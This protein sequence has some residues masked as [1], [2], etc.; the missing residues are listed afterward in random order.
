ML[1]KVILALAVLGIVD[2]ALSLQ[3][4][5]VVSQ[6]PSSAIGPVPVAAIGIAGYL[7]LAL[8][9]WF[10]RRGWTLLFAWIG[11]GFAAYFSYVE[12]YVL[13]AWSAYCVISQILIAA[14]AILAA[15]D[16]GI[17]I[18][19]KIRGATDAVDQVVTS[20]RYG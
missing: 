19:K 6:S 10:H 17:A 3:G 5:G 20:L 12:A 8:L 18:A 15:I 2:S 4:G 7:L 11:L 16:A 9:A 13:G 1:R 14:I